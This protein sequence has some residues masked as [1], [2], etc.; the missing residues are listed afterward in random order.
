LASLKLE[1]F[2]SGQTLIDAEL[3]DLIHKPFFL[4]AD[5][6]FKLLEHEE[7]ELARKSAT[8]ARWFSLGAI[9]V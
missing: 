5:S 9:T 8:S 1:L 6:Y 3:D 7:L 4:K 2:G